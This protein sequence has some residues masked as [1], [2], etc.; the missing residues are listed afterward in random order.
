MIKPFFIFTQLNS[1]FKVKVA[2][3]ENL[4]VEQIKSI[5]NFVEVRKGVFDFDTYS[6]VIQKK[7]EFSEFLSLLKHLG[8]DA[9]CE[10]EFEFSTT[11]AK[12]EF[13]KYKGV[14]Y[15]E[16]PDSYLLWLKSN[17]NGKDRETITNE[18]QR[19]GI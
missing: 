6:F 16:V 5:Q 11:D 9:E 15:T 12:I 18:I 17:Y 19:R 8:I 7:I 3:L 14:S 13:G 10:E 1:C 4:S 2:N